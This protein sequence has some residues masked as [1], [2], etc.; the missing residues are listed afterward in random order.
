MET[1]EINLLCVVG[2]KDQMG[3]GIL[4]HT[5]RMQSAMGNAPRNADPERSPPSSHPVESKAG[6]TYLML[7]KSIFLI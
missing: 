4:G 1:V 2:M 6:V 7:Q 5:S 3:D